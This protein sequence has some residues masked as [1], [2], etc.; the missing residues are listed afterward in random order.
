MDSFPASN[1]DEREGP[2][3]TF[4]LE[5]ASWLIRYS[6]DKPDCTAFRNA[7][8]SYSSPYLIVCT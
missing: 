1:A 6:K 8:G 2:P 3:P 4:I 5:S 7:R